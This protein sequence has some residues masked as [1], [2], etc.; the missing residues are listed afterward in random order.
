MGVTPVNF[1]ELMAEDVDDVF[2]DT[3]ENAEEHDIDGQTVL[4][5][6][7]Q[8]S[9]R[10][11]SDRQNETYDGIF[12]A[13]AMLAVKEAVLGYRPVFGQAMKVDGTM[14][15]VAKCVEDSGLLLVTLEANES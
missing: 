1:K 13:T 15:L 7:D 12:K 2:L 6:V 3:D 11:R 10:E 5:S 4:C 9:S 14:Y 8:V